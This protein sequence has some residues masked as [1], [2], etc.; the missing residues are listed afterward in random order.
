M[1]LSMCL[2]FFLMI[3]RPP[4]STRTDTLFPY[5]TLFRS[6]WDL[7]RDSPGPWKEQQRTIEQRGRIV[8][9]ELETKASDG[10][11]R[12]IRI[13]GK[14]I[15]DQGGHYIG[16]R[17]TGTDVTATVLA[18]REAGRR[19]ELLDNSFENLGQGVAI[20]DRDR[21]VVMV[22]RHLLEILDIPEGELTIG[23]D[24]AD[25][26]HYLA[27]RGEYGPGD[28]RRLAEERYA[29]I[30]CT[31]PYTL[32]HQRPN[33]RI[34][35]V[36][37]QPLPSGG[38]VIACR[39]V[40]GKRMAQATLESSE[41]FMR[42]IIDSALDAFV[43]VD[44]SDRVL[45]WNSSAEKIF[46]WSRDEAIGRSLGDLILPERLRAAHRELLAGGMK[47][48]GGRV[49]GGRRETTARRRDG[50]EFPVEASL[51]AQ[52]ADGSTIFT[53]FIRD[54]TPRRQFESRLLQAKE[55]AEA[56]SRAKSQFLANM[57][58]E[59]RTPL[60]AIIGFAGIMVRQM[61]GPLGEHYAED[62]G[63]IHQ[64]GRHPLDLIKGEGRAPG[65][66][67]T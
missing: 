24:F 64:S 36:R 60:N 6:S 21:K 2:F 29:M 19:R 40:T 61:M 20:V 34:I 10:T 14:P 62:A 3:R 56:A 35:E 58:H 32:E 48:D 41:R 52:A 7:S 66:T 9:F 16:Y 44:R 25:F 27:R 33:G 5:T 65:W 59:L 50:T 4:G 57:S 42:G 47:G 13:S 45:D 63:G 67:T 11:M 51:S 53:A 54:I 55:A 12:T 17:G 26:F 1:M 43:S 15:Y 38:V 39:D 18:R 49:T 31:Q 37:G 8:E 30:A 46:G 22:N 23:S 28:P